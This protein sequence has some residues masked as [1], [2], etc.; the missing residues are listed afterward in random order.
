MLG[1]TALGVCGCLG[2]QAV[3]Y[4]RSRYN[5]VIQTSNKEE[6]LLNLVR[7][8]YLED[9]G[10]LPVTGLTA[11]FEVDAGAL[12]RGGKDRGG[13]SHYGEANMSFADRPTITFAPQRSPELTKG[14]LTR[15]P[16]E[17]LFLFVAN[18][19]DQESPLAV[20]RPQYERDRQRGGGRRSNSGKS[21][22]IHRVP[23]CRR[24]VEPPES[25]APGGPG[26]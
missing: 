4:T 15:I 13:A 3:H 1:C 8:R 20:I 18:A 16:L 7:L 9:P 22:R 11:Q 19:A 21:S 26:D 23:L 6:L 24:A 17:T 14:L 5:E 25:R 2:P 10:F 12:G